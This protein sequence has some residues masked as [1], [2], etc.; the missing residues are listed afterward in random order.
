MA[1]DVEKVLGDTFARTLLKL[2]VI[3]LIVGFVMATFDIDPWGLIY[4]I[5]KFITDIW[6]NGFAALGAIGDYLILGGA[7]VLP[8]FIVIRL[9]SYRR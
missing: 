7:I 6:Y 9:L 3:S 4:T 2:V 1:R 5:R 8:V